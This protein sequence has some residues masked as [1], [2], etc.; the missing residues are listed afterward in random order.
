VNPGVESAA[1][2]T[3][4]SS[5]DGDFASRRPNPAQGSRGVIERC[6]IERCVIERCVIERCVIERCVIEQMRVSR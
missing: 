1:P 6:V 5:L 2:P 4:P 3:S